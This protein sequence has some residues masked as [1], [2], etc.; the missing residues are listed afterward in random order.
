M[1]TLL[2][3]DALS[4]RFTIH[5]LERELVAFAEVSFTLRAG[6]LLLVRGPNG[7]G[8]SSLLRC[9][10]RT[11]RPDGGTAIFGSR[12]G[13]I[14][15]VRA[16]DV[17]MALLRRTEIGHVT[18]FLRPRPRVSALD[19][20]AEPL[21]LAGIGPDDATE[22]AGAWLA[23]LGLKRTIWQA[24]PSTFSGGEQQ[25]INLARAMIAP[26]RLLLLDEPTSALDPAARQALRQRIAALKQ[27]GVAMIGIF[28]HAEDVAGLV[29]AEV[30]LRVPDV[31]I[32][33]RPIAD[34]TTV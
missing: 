22:Q 30:Q 16:A 28:H 6:E 8:K 3:V 7:V 24:Y 31:K 29:D 14:D 15:L 27:Q 20:V 21:L 5:A 32:A 12:Y 34:S 19:L 23:D 11:Y 4:K 25:K 26:R 1:S 17:D 9:L 13:P 33:D 18:Q 10:Y 2:T